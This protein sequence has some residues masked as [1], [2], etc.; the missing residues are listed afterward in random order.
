MR[1]ALRLQTRRLKTETYKSHFIQLSACLTL[2][3]HAGIT[4]KTL[5]KSKDAPAEARTC[6]CKNP[7][8]ISS[9]TK[10]ANKSSFPYLTA[11]N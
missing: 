6:A 2:E 8:T 9:R 3:A 1:N 7:S 5:S 10:H 4:R 11:T